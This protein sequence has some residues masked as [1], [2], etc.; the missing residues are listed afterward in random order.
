MPESS[1]F[2]LP[3]TFCLAL[4]WAVHSGLLTSQSRLNVFCHLYEVCRL[5]VLLDLYM[6][7]CRRIM[8]FDQILSN[9]MRVLR[10]D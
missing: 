8:G 3:W 1:S 9:F 5:A 4:G 7:V 6:G 2:M 10:Q